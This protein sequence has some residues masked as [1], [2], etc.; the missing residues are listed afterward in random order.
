[1]TF[2]FYAARNKSVAFL[3]RVNGPLC[4][5][6][7]CWLFAYAYELSYIHAAHSYIGKEI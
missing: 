7:S 4:V 6:Y 3:A 1:M 2:R 5:G